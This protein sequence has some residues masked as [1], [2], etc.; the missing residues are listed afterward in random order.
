MIIAQD[1]RSSPADIPGLF[2]YN[3]EYGVVQLL[4]NN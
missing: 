1:R 2:A 4:H 3:T